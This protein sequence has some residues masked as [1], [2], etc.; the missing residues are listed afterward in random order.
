MCPLERFMLK[1][2][3]RTSLYHL[4]GTIVQGHTC[5]CIEFYFS[6]VS[7]G[8]LV[9]IAKWVLLDSNV[10]SEHMVEYNDSKTRSK[11]QMSSSV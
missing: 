7:V 11:Q 8:I 9:L 6:I 5:L 3:S 4:C 10:N 1:N 2:L